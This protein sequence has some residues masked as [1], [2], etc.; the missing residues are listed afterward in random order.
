LGTSGV[1]GKSGLFTL[2][3]P[4]ELVALGDKLTQ[5]LQLYDAS[6]KRVFWDYL[7]IPH[8]YMYR[9]PIAKVNINLQK[10]ASFLNFLFI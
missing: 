6:G 4:P 9:I 5:F 7:Y 3:T 8:T 10:T 2:A 1:V